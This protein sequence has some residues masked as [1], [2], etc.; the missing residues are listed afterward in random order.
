MSE[1]YTPKVLPLLTYPDERLRSVAEKVTTFNEDTQNLVMD[2]IATMTTN[3]GIGLAAPQ[4]GISK[5]IITVAVGEN[6][7]ALINPVIVGSSGRI[8]SKEGCLSVPGYYENVDRFKQITVSYQT[9]QG[10]WKESIAKDLLAVVVQHEIDHLDGKLF[11]DYLSPLK[12]NRAR[13]KSKKMAK[14]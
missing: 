12:Q 5:R 10:D 14:Q 2:M 1:Q 13:E 7:L 3:N 11:V 6:P 8:S 9:V 4:V